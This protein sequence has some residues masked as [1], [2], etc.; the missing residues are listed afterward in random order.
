MK[1]LFE[2]MED[3]ECVPVKDYEKKDYKVVM[4]KESEE[5]VEFKIKKDGEVK[6]S[7]FS[8]KVDENGIDFSGDIS[9]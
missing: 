2:D 7:L 6:Q 4:C 9:I 3:G 8:Q 1:G 5:E